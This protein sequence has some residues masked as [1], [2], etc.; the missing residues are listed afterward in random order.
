MD[1][2]AEQP[3]E[4]ETQQEPAKQSSKKRR[5][6]LRIALII[7]AVLLII[8]ILV[9]GW[10]GFVPGL[11]SVFGATKPRDLGVRYTEADYAAFQEKASV[12]FQDFANAPNN[13]AQPDKKVVFS[14]AE[15]QDNLRLT[16]EEITAAV[17]STNWLWMPI[18]NAQVRLSGNTVEVSGNLNVAY[19]DKFI[20]FIGGV[21]YSQEDVNTAVDWGK[22][23]VNNAPVYIKANAS[24][25]N[26]QLSFQLQEA[27]VGR[28]NVPQDI[29]SRVL[30]TGSSNALKKTPNLDIQSAQIVDSAITFSGTHPSTV[31]VK[32]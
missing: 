1:T 32:R 25:S 14:G 10:L 5:R 29:A 28:F 21:G 15:Q 22:R 23:F 17:N 9:A 8:P 3:S 30:G 20:P 26:N 19:L 12:T 27:Q 18:K 2:A 7:V 24:V 16:Q 13:P 6:G 4:T 11:S 31:Y